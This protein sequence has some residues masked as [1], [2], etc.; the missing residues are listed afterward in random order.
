[1]QQWSIT[2]ASRTGCVRTRNEDMIL[3]GNWC[4]RSGKIS[5]TVDIGES[6]R[7]LCAVADG[8]GGYSGGDEASKLTL[9]NL[10]FYFND[11]PN[12]L[13]VESFKKA[14]DDWFQ[15]ICRLISQRG[16]TNT[17]LFNM[18]TTLVGMAYYEG[19][20]YWMNCGD[21]R[22]YMLHEGEVRQLTTDHTLSSG[23][24]S[25]YVTNCIGAGSKS[26]FLDQS[27][28]TDIIHDGDVLLLCSDGLSELVPEHIIA[29][30]LKEGFDADALCDS[31]ED[32]GGI[33]N[34][35]A[36]VIRIKKD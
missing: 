8:M 30:M 25:G 12:G 16:H 7:F 22:L 27:V 36:I 15:S 24:H 4:G 1:M 28:F 6:D 35:S 31:A 11:M 13:H 29:R 34:V 21:S 9:T 19:Q 14:V 26:S 33:D 20:Y 23:K 18:G 5:R 2:A 10:Q 32:A 17:E 3:V